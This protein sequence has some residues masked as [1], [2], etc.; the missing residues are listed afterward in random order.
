MNDTLD[1]DSLSRIR[2][3][4]SAHK[5][6]IETGRFENKNQTD[7]ICRLC[8]DGIGNELYY[9]TECKNKAVTKT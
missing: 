5:F 3:R 7:R 8:C 6:P 1:F 9:L 4:I 2:I